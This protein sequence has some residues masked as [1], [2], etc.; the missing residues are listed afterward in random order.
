M[1]TETVGPVLHDVRPPPGAD[2]VRSPQGRFVD[3]IHGVDFCGD[4]RGDPAQDLA[5]A[6]DSDP[7]IPTGG[8]WVEDLSAL[9]FQTRFDGNPATGDAVDNNLDNAVDPGVFHGT[10]VAGVAAAMTDN[11]S[12]DPDTPGFEGMAGVCWHC[13]IMPVR[14][15]NAEGWAYGSD[16][17]AAARAFS[18]WGQ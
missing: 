6:Q 4:N 5:S 16:A 8:T 13:S 17:A 15:I 1:G 11:V 2:V 18:S 10:A 7:D 9:P 14:I 12:L 3:D